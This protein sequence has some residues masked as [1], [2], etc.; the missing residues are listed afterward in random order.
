MWFTILIVIML[1]PVVIYYVLKIVPVEKPPYSNL[2]GLRNLPQNK[3]LALGSQ[4]FGSNHEEYVYIERVLRE[5]E[6]SD[7]KLA[8]YI[9][10]TEEQGAYLRDL[11]D[12]KSYAVRDLEYEKL[13]KSSN[14]SVKRLEKRKHFIDETYQREQSEV[15]A[16]E[17]PIT[18]ETIY[19]FV[20]FCGQAKITY[21]NEDVVKIL[22]LLEEFGAFSFVWHESYKASDVKE[23]FPDSTIV[24]NGKINITFSTPKRNGAL[25]I[26]SKED[27]RVEK[28]PLS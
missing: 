16:W 28:I 17:P 15:L 9:K 24:G 23:T 22:I 1:S 19:T 21:E 26:F 20:E 11:D 25:F 6:R 18:H 3:G 2:L 27:A 12:L 14:Q 10:T 8:D 13:L 7:K 4:K 5:W